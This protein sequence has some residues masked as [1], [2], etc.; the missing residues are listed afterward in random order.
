L[1]NDRWKPLTRAGSA[2]PPRVTE[3]GSGGNAIRASSHGPEDAS[4][5]VYSRHSNGLEQFFEYIRGEAG[6]RLLDLSGAS[7]ANIGFITNLGHRL[8]SEDLLRSLDFAFGNEPEF[9]ENQTVQHRIDTFLEQTLNFPEGHFDGALVWDALEFLAP[10]LLKAF[11]DRLHFVVRPRSYL[12]AVFHAQERGETIPA[13]SYRIASPGTLTLPLRSL[14]RPAQFFNNRAVEKIF[15]PFESVKFFLT[16]DSLR[17]VI[18]K[19]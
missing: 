1:F 17:E 3:P 14:R 12:L 11:V 8:Y 2:G 5:R 10:P 16:R 18:V 6:L 19:R 7:Q 4:Q 13:Y 9:Y 15:Q